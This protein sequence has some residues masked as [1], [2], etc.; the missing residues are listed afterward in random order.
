MSYGAGSQKN[1]MSGSQQSTAHSVIF[2]GNTSPQSQQQQQ[3]YSQGQQQAG[4]GSE[5]LQFY[6][7]GMSMM[8][9]QQGQQYN[10]QGNFPMSGGVNGNIS[11]VM[12]GGGGIDAKDRLFVGHPFG[13]GAYADENP[14]LEELGINFSHIWSKSVSVLN[15]FRSPDRHIMDDTDLAGPIVFCILFGSFLLLSGKVH[16]GYVYGLAVVGCVSMWMILNLMSENGIDGYKTSSV[17]GYCLL[18]MVILSSVSIL[19]KVVGQVGLIFAVLSIAWC[20]YSA[21]TMFVTVLGM[22]DQRL[23]VGYPVGLFYTAFAMLTIF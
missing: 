20:T 6:N 13:T 7:S 19:L 22:K 2:D 9:Q 14:L 4:Y 3:Y 15:I 8:N 18:P 17:L 10:T 16:F 1:S 12:G 23:L 11:G 5:Q 21:S